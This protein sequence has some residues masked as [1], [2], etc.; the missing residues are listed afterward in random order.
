VRFKPVPA[1]VTPGAIEHL[2]RCFREVLS[3]GAVERTLADLQRAG[4]ISS[5]GRGRYA[6]CKKRYDQPPQAG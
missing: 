2:V 6:V 1:F 3:A 5:S 4:D